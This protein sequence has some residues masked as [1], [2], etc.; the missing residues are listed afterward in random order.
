MRQVASEAMA[1][2]YD[3]L[4]GRTTY[5]ISAN[6]FAGSEEGD[7]VIQKL[8]KA[9]KYVVTSNHK[10]LLW[11]N[12]EQI[13][14]NII[15]K[16]Y[17]LKAQD[18]PLLQVHGSWQLI[19]FLLDNDV[20]DEFRLWTFPIIAG[21]GKRVFADGAI[22]KHLKLLKFKTTTPGVIMNFWQSM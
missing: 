15:E 7:P 5:E 19:Q 16:I 1:E 10:K 13:T 4:L 20:V 3:L 21:G 9:K 22:P 12:S 17:Q 6:S 8:N 18:G 11:H 2:P 14:G